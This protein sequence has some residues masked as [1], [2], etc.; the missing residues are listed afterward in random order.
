MEQNKMEKDFRNK[1]NL[2]EIEPR[3]NA[4]DRLDAML[5]VA[6]EKKPKRN[7]GWMYIAAGILGFLFVG[8][9]FFSQIEE[10][11]DVRRNYVVLE[12]NQKPSEN[13]IN[14]A[15]EIVPATTSETIV[16]VTEPKIKI[17]PNHQNQFNTINPINTAPE[18]NKNQELIANNDKGESIITRATGEQAAGNQ[19]TEQQITPAK[20]DELLAN[21]TPTPKAGSKTIK[22]NSKSLLSQVD[23]EINLTFREKIIRK[24]G[25]NYQEVADA[26][27]NRNAQ[28]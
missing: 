18:A 14:K 28:Q 12:T 9:I 25:K 2:R 3:A 7:Y 4:W 27:S 16:A 1:L 6:E 21:V 23:G 24:V 11:I 22:V 13:T 26:V 19:K 10:M 20:V 8:T 15:E 17:K 5:T